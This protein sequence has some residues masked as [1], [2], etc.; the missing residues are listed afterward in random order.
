LTV[1]KEFVDRV[2]VGRVETPMACVRLAHIGAAMTYLNATAA[3]QQW[4]ALISIITFS[5]PNIL[6]I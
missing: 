1:I 6:I 3:G 4:I 5:A 2:V